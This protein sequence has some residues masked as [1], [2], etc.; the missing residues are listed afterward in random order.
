MDSNS[1]EVSNSS[2]NFVAEEGSQVVVDQPHQQ[3]VEV[4][5]QSSKEKASVFEFYKSFQDTTW[6]ECGHHDV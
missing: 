6:L 4:A 1:L 3:S 2:A 5:G